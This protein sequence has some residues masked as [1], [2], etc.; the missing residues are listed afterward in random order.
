MENVLA[1]RVTDEETIRRFREIKEYLGLKNDAEVFRL[2]V[3]SF[4]RKLRGLTD[5]PVILGEVKSNGI[6]RC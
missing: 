3:N 4:W 5:F 1:V 6:K 2:L